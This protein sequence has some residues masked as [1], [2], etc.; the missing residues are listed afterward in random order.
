MPSTLADRVR[1]QDRLFA[2]LSAMFGREVPLYDRSLAVNRVCN[3]TV[4][5]L[6]SGFHDLGG[7]VGSIQRRAARRHPYRPPR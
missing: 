5:S 1:M 7:P 3:Q 2:E 4:C 6:V